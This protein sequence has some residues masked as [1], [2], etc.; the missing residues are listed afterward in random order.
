M[1]KVIDA[2]TKTVSRFVETRKAG[3][4]AGF[5]TGEPMPE[6]DSVV[7]MIVDFSACTQEQIL[8]LAE[9]SVVISWQGKLRKSKD[10]ADWAATEAN[11]DAAEYLR[12]ERPTD[13]VADAR[14]ALKRLSPE[15]LKLIKDELAARS[16]NRA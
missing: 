2:T 7:A 6:A 9:R 3:A 1:G 11:I 5:I 13:P 16:N 8:D 4:K 15:M 14:R 12:T 10:A